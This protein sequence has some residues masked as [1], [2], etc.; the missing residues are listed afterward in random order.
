MEILMRMDPW[1]DHP[2]N[3]RCD[4]SDHECA[5]GRQVLQ[6]VRQPDSSVVF[7][8]S[9]FLNL[10]LCRQ[11][12]EQLHAKPFWCPWNEKDNSP[13]SGRF[14]GNKTGW[15]T[16]DILYQEHRGVGYRWKQQVAGFVGRQS[17]QEGPNTGWG[18]RSEHSVQCPVWT[19]EGSKSPAA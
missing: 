1:Q 15:K 13:V 8:H 7:C 6:W 14:E 3:G 2:P 17:W 16:E 19:A 11:G 12:T 4:F 18:P 10:S 5:P 9:I